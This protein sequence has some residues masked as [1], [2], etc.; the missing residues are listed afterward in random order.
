MIYISVLIK[1]NEAWDLPPQLCVLFSGVAGI[2]VIV[3]QIAR[4]QFVHLRLCGLQIK[5]LFTHTSSPCDHSCACSLCDFWLTLDTLFIGSHR[6]CFCDF[7]H[8][9][10]SS[11]FFYTVVWG[12]SILFLSRHVSYAPVTSLHAAADGNLD[13]FV[14]CE[15]STKNICLRPCWQCCKLLQAQLMILF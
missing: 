2:P 10:M 12:G 11:W 5:C 6:V 8:T 13:Y 7:F 3:K 14:Y 9:F 1:K 15:Y 4:A